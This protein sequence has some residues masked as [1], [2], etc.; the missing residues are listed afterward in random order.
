MQPCLPLLRFNLRWCTHADQLSRPLCAGGFNSCD[1]HCAAAMGP[2]A[3]H[4]RRST[5]ARRQQMLMLA[6]AAALAAVLS[7]SGQVLTPLGLG[8]RITA[9]NF[10]ALDNIQL[11]TSAQR[12]VSCASHVLCLKAPAPFVLQM[13]KRVPCR[14]HVGT[15]QVHPTQH[16]A[17]DMTCTISPF[18]CD[19]Q[20][21]TP[22]RHDFHGGRC[23]SP[24]C[25][26]EG[27]AGLH[28]Q[29]KL[30]VARWLARR[31]MMRMGLGC[32]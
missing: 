8:T 7:V 9:A 12:V 25:G 26:C 19:A 5:R 32:C 6:A 11:S 29:G 28:L 10:E 13:M 2:C 21:T 16:C 15:G 20:D 4:A 18:I 17:I 31:H 14:A 1:W 22:A 23:T 30:M 3:W 24:L 27:W